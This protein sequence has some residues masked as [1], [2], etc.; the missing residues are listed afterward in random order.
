MS[1][2]VKWGLLA[3]GLAILIGLVIA[4]PFTGLI[5]FNELSNSV[6]SLVSVAGQ[7][8]YSGRCLVNNFLSPAGRTIFSGLLIYLCIK[9]AVTIG[10]KITAWI[11]H[12]IFRG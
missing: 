12:F 10:V 9:W 1:N 3:A 8:L 2:A 5:D 11:Y 4:L 6:G 7:A